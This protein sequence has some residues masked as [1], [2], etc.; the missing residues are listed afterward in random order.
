MLT[1]SLSEPRPTLLRRFLDQVARFRETLDLAFELR[2]LGPAAAR[3]V[4]ERR[5]L[6]QHAVVGGLGR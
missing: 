3:D 2:R 5:G 6:I 4:L 1:W